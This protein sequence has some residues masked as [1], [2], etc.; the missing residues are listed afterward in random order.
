[1]HPFINELKTALKNNMLPGATAHAV[2]SPL[3]RE[4][5]EE[6]LAKAIIP[7]RTSA[8]MILLFEENKI[9]K[10]VLIRRPSYDGVHSG[11]ISFP[12]GKYE[13]NDL[14]FK[15]TALRE[16]FEEVGIPPDQINV[17][18]A[19]SRIYIPPSNFLVY[20]YVGYCEKPPSFIPDEKEVDR[21]IFP[22]INVLLNKEIRKEGMF[23]SGGTNSWK[24]Q[25]PYY[26]IENEKVWGATAIILSEFKMIIEKIKAG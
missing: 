20:P 1:M 21:L 25:A 2:M 12:G 23:N 11:Q 18:G 8:V 5:T 4:D 26:E 16:T 10:M 7:A 9:C 17:I 22:D 19:L 15:T 14:D 3:G 13:E 24:I 6:Y